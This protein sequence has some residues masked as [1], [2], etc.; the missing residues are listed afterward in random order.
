MIGHSDLSG[1]KRRF[2]IVAIT[3]RRFALVAAAVALLTLV[4]FGL[5]QA[6]SVGADPAR[7]VADA[8]AAAATADEVSLLAAVPLRG[9]GRIVHGTVTI[10]SPKDGLITVQ[11]DGGMIAAVD[12][13]SVT[14]AEKGGANVTVGIDSDTRVRRNRARAAVADLKVGDTV[15]VVS[16][17][18]SGGTATA[19]AI[20]VPPAK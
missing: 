14:I 7:S 9:R 13:A 5:V 16:R 18:A 12:G 6:S 15:R 17:V 11:I 20:V 10:D 19:R 2:T 8:P 4:G 3:R 1:T